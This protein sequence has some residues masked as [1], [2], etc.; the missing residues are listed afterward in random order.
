MR[1]ITILFA[2]FTLLDLSH[3]DSDRFLTVD[4]CDELSYEHA[5]PGSEHTQPRSE[6]G[7]GAESKEHCHCHHGHSHVSIAYESVE[8][9]SPFYFGSSKKLSLN[10]AGKTRKYFPEI[11]RPPILFYSFS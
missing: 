7:E 3:F 1:L 2:L 11:H 8:A 5:Q 10:L 9:P 6:H 4:N